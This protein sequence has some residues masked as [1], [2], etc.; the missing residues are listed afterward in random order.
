PFG[1]GNAASVLYR[2][3]H[4]A[5]DLGALSPRLREIVAECLAKDPADRPALGLLATRIAAQTSGTESRR[6]SFW[7]PSVAGHIERF[8]AS[9]ETELGAA[10]DQA[11]EVDEADETSAI[12]TLRAD[13]PV[14]PEPPGT[15][16]GAV[17]LMYA[18]AAYALVFAAFSWLIA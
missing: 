16:R 4:D 9:L 10:A 8:Q 7:P 15:I 6:L 17:G 5:P 1:R 2:V 12:R 14:C 3:V 13:L 18:G 11:D